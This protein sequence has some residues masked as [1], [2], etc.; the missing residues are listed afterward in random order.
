MQK[1]EVKRLSHGRMQKKKDELLDNTL[2][3]FEDR[4]YRRVR[5]PDIENLPNNEH[6]NRLV[7]CETSEQNLEEFLKLGTKTPRSYRQR[8]NHVIEVD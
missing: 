4:S 5:D 6:S 2:K 3:Y 8:V 7:I 1:E